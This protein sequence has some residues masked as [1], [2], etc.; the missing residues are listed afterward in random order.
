MSRLTVIVAGRDVDGV[1]S[2][3]IAAR[4][5]GGPVEML[6]FEADRLA[7]FFDSP[8]QEK[9]PGLYRLIICGLGVVHTDWDGEV[10]RPRLMQALRAFV[11]PLLWFSAAEWRSED[12]AA[13]Q[14]ILGGSRLTMSE[15]ASCAAEL[16]RDRLAAPD[17]AHAELL[18]RFAAGRL[19]P[20]AEAD[21][22]KPWRRVIASLRDESGRL[23]EAV[24]PL[25]EGRPG[26]IGSALIERAER[27]ER[28]NRQFAADHAGEL[29][30]VG[31]RK[32]VVIGVP[33]Q[34]HAFWREIS[35]HARSHAEA[36]FCLCLLLGRP[37]MILTRDPEQRT[38]LRIWVRYLT[39]M[40]PIAM[41]VG[42]RLD[43]VPV[44]LRGLDEDAGLAQVAVD[45]L[46]EG[47]HLLA[48]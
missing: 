29:V 44:I 27:V 23:R 9:L 37:V 22:G 28:E 26:E 25:I 6:F 42:A 13:V 16:V 41:V 7:A 39:D 24:A 35:D 12:R 19:P 1:A 45:V 48:T 11:G 32:L 20:Q 34:R 46:R 2:A 21:W 18:V 31:E 17:D 36:D 14:N 40:L 4:A 30:P 47:A 3:A 10:I 5:A 43:A 38:D 8:V 33:R 15:S